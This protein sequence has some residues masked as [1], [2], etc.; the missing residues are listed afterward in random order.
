MKSKE[1]NPN[2][3]DA[4]NRRKAAYGLMVIMTTAPAF[5]LDRLGAGVFF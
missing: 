5:I 3:I 1:A 2:L 4:S